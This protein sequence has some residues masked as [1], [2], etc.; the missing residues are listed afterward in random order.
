MLATALIE[1]DE[2]ARLLRQVPVEQRPSGKRVSALLVLGSLRQNRAVKGE[3]D[4][5]A[6]RSQSLGVVD[7]AQRLWV[8]HRHQ[9]QD[10]RG[11][12]VQRPGDRQMDAGRR[13]VSHRLPDRQPGAARRAI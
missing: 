11:L 3:Q 5:R 10:V 8:D 12:A 9:L 7:V 1:N 2:G 4:N 13:R 6:A